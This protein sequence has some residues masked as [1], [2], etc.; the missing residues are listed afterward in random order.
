MKNSI[1]VLHTLVFCIFST[2]CD[3]PDPDSRA[4]YD[5]E[6]KQNPWSV[7]QGGLSCDQGSYPDW[8]ICHE[9][10]PLAAE[11]MRYLFDKNGL[12]SSTNMNEVQSAEQSDLVEHTLTRYPD[13]CSKEKI[14][15]YD[16]AISKKLGPILSAMRE[17]QGDD[18][19]LLDSEQYVECR[20]EEIEDW[21]GKSIVFE[22]QYRRC[23]Y[24]HTLN[25][26]D[27]K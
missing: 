18:L 15:G 20:L 22:V 2:A 23:A 17:L 25:S 26:S 12:C 4:M 14:V 13:S 16:E 11:R 6:V 8:H 3:R 27:L 24:R 9:S 7:G 1:I 19:P 21:Y 5:Q 10:E